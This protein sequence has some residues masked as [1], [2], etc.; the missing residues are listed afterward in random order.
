MAARL[1]PTEVMEINR[2]Y[3]I[4]GSYAEVARIIGRSASA[5]RKYVKL[6]GTP[7]AARTALKKAATK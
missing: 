6:D 7:Q 5:V 1:T 4:H 3:S 2:L